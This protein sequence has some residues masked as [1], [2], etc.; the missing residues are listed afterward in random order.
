MVSKCANPA[1]K[2]AFRYFRGGKLFL[3]DSQ[4]M[5]AADHKSSNAR[6]SEYF[7]LCEQCASALTVT[8]ANNGYPHVQERST[9]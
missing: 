8:L 5:H 3:V 6:R 7:W 1:C 9:R 2:T 4:P